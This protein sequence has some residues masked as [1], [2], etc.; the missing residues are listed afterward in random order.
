MR[1]LIERP[2]RGLIE[3]SDCEKGR[4][5]GVLVQ[6][7]LDNKEFGSSTQSLC[8][9]LYTAGSLAISMISTDRASESG[10][11]STIEKRLELYGV[12][13]ARRVRISGHRRINTLVDLCKSVHGDICGEM[14]RKDVP[15]SP[16][17]DRVLC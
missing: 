10:R 7:R 13:C 1:G 8:S 12:S 11:R 14:P 3:R 5:K 9:S 17:G 16:A 4:Y 2:D 15:T 6:H